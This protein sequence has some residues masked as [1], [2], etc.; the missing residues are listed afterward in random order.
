MEIENIEDI[1]FT[2]GVIPLKET[3]ITSENNNIESCTVK[4]LD[5]EVISSSVYKLGV[6]FV[7]SI[8]TINGVYLVISKFLNRRL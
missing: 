4:L 8:L 3:T 7:K 2:N 5:L 1:N 6:S